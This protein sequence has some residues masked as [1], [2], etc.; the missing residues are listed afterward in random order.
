MPSKVAIDP[1]EPSLGRIRADSIPPPH[2]V[3][4]IK[5][6]ISR[7]E[8][9]PELAHAELFADISCETPLK[10]GHIP[11]LRIECPG[12]SPNK[13]MAI[14]QNVQMPTVTIEIPDGKYVIKNR[15]ADIFWNIGHNPMKNVYFFPTTMEQA[16]DSNWLQVNKH[17]AIIQVFKG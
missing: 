6:C 5:R 8:R 1:E 11:I 10:E 17:S 12:L 7:V 16:K 3:A 9:T 14:V 2:S 15:A 4:S 13:P